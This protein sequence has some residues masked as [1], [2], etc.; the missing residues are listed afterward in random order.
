M[1]PRNVPP[2][3]AAPRSTTRDAANAIDNA[4]STQPTPTPVGVAWGPPTIPPIPHNPTGNTRQR[5]PRRGPSR[6][7]G[8]GRSTG[9]GRGDRPP[10]QTTTHPSPH[11]SRTNHRTQIGLLPVTWTPGP[12]RTTL[13]VEAFRCTRAGVSWR[14]HVVRVHRLASSCYCERMSLEVYG[15]PVS[16]LVEVNCECLVY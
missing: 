11:L 10:H 16:V 13:P 1:P 15:I 5:R 7:T 8:P 6:S 14:V 4:G 2:V 3:A 12:L 9:R